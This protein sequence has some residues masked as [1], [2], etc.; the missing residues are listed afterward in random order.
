[1]RVEDLIVEVRDENLKRQWQ[2]DPAHLV[3]SLFAPRANGVGTW[4]V[5]LPA[6]VDGVDFP[7]CTALRAPGAGIIVTTPTGVLISGPTDYEALEQ[8]TED[9]DGMWTITGWS[10]DILPHDDLAWPDPET[11]EVDVDGNVTQGRA[12]DTQTDTVEDLLRYY[13]SANI[14][15]DAPAERK[16]GTFYESI[17]LQPSLSRGPTVTASPRFDNLLELMQGI[18]VGT[19]VLFRLAQN[20]DDEIELQISEAVDRTG[21]WRFDIDNEQLQSTQHGTGAPSLTHA[22][23]AGQEQGVNRTVIL[24]TSTESLAA[25]AAWKRRPAKFIDQRQT[26]DLTELQGKGDAE[27]ALGGVP[28]SFTVEPAETIDVLAARDALGSRIT[29]VIGDTPIPARLNQV[30]V[31]VTAEGVTTAAVIGDEDG[32]DWEGQV[33]RSLSSLGSRVSNLERNPVGFSADWAVKGGP[34]SLASA[35]ENVWAVGFDGGGVLDGESNANGI[36]VGAD[37]VYEIEG[38]QRGDGANVYVTL[39]LDGSRTALETHAD[40]LFTHDHSAGANNYST[41]SYIGRLSAGDII[42]LGGPTSTNLVYASST[43]TGFIKARR[44]G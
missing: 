12:N 43:L 41:S 15:P 9:P 26:D 6:K 11:Y 24:R 1:M 21:E 37:G 33:V 23:V 42:T 32:T 38:A 25:A 40:G 34:T 7:P 28:S 17:V 31:G 4:K 39:A 3:G 35:Y 44:I 18:C 19:D 10:D 27:L 2:I 13:V 8:T 29:I 36:V 22:L 20:D 5:I 14:G 30:I 16:T